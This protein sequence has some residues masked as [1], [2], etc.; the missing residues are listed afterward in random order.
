MTDGNS[1]SSPLDS[2]KRYVPL[3][4]WTIVILVV[5]IIPLKVIKYGYLPGDDLVAA[6]GQGGERQAVVGNSRAQ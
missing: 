4:V 3:A 1:N 6:R 2:L 5:L